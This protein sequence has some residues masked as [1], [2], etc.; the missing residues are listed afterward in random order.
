SYVVYLGGQHEDF[1]E[2]ESVTNSH[3]E[4][5][6]STL[7]S[8]EA[9]TDSIFYSYKSFKGFAADLEEE[10]AAAISKL[11]GVVSVFLNREHKLHTTRSWGFLGLEDGDPKSETEEIPSFSLWR[12][13][14]FGKDVIVANLD[15]GVWPESASFH[16]RGFGP[17]PS[18]WRG[19]CE[20][21]AQFSS[22]NCNRKLIGA[23]YYIKG[24]LN[25]KKPLNFTATGD[26]LSTRDKE[27]HGTHTLST[28]GGNFVKNASIFGFGE[29]TAKG[30]APGARVAA[31]KVCWAGGSCFDAD[32]L[33]GF[34][35]GVYD[36]VDVFSVSLGS[37]PPLADYFQ[38]G[39]SIGAF[40]A[41]QRG[42]V[43]VCSAGNDGPDA[44]TV[45]NVAPWI[46]TVGASSID[47]QFP[48]VAFL[49][50]NRSY[51]GQ[52][53]SD[54]TLQ[55][56]M[57]CLVSS[58]DVTAPT[59]NKTD[60]QLCF[61]GA[62]DPRKV[63]GKIVAC[64]RGQNSR[65]A[66]GEAVRMAGGAGM[67]LCNAPENGDEIVADAHILPAT[68][69]N[70]VDGAAVSDYIK[71]TKSPV[72]YIGPARTALDT[73]PAPFMA[74]FSSTGPNTLSPDILKPDITAPG[75]NILAAYTNASSPTG[76]TF[77]DRHVNFN[78]IS[79]T[80]MACPH[81]AGIAALLKAAYPHWS[82]AA[83]KSAIMTTASRIDNTKQPIKEASMKKATPFNYGAGHVDPN[84]AAN[85]GLIY[86]LSV[87]DYYIFFC[88]LG[89]NS[90]QI[91]VLTGKMFSCPP[92]K[93]ALY[94]LNYPSITVAKLKEPVFV[95]RTVTYVSDGPAVFEAQVESPHGV[96]V[97][98]KPNKI[99]FS[100]YGEKK[101]FNVVMKPRNN[102][103]G[104]YVF[105]SL[106]WKSANHVVRS[107]IVVKAATSLQHSN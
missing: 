90:S 2:P 51:E 45:A 71:S 98:V 39:I 86:D 89:Y 70:A 61:Q 56:K 55:K 7:G 38:D 33:A 21:D 30:G 47:R 58:V 67:I 76:I 9:A 99:E 23:R 25:A 105:G 82:P 31:Y 57:Y 15:T 13:A 81:V 95:K 35:A 1:L 41:V 5:L 104:E 44:G 80:S 16:D 72:A 66:K 84:R 6:L 74:A 50:N 42:K 73:K 54:F 59:A 91:K 27:G 77:D 75:L 43:V 8:K 79:G 64:L 17:I 87:K 83:I 20:N 97:T 14:G 36:G 18:K 103:K 53:L 49:G 3:H 69:L 52:S 106:T 24:Y 32:I 12:K 48:S 68:H 60:G 101:S 26:F 63:K 29:G 28:A 65:V 62:L 37:S 96:L 102:F 46:I 92:Q 107:P 88:N 22:A 78:I 93:D 85:P 100:E 10:H 4:L 40:H 19:G 94:N 34:D 11:P